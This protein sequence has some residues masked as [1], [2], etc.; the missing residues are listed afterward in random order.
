MPYKPIFFKRDKD[1]NQYA[2][3]NDDNSAFKPNLNDNEILL[4]KLTSKYCPI[5]RYCI[6]SVM[7]KGV[8]IY[9][10]YFKGFFQIAPDHYSYESFFCNKDG[11]YKDVAKLEPVN[12]PNGKDNCLGCE[13]IIKI[14]AIPYPEKSNCHVVCD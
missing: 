6:D 4:D 10:E 7:V 11:K 5:R 2:I 1:G 13:K 8:N 3:I 14:V 9:C 12:C